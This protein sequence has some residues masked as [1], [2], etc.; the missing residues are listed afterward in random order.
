MSQCMNKRVLFYYRL[1]RISLI[2]S[3]YYFL[4]LVDP[5]RVKGPVG[6]LEGIRIGVHG[7]HELIAGASS[8]PAPRARPHVPCPVPTDIRIDH[9]LHGSKAGSAVAITAAK[10][11]V[12]R[13]LPPFPGINGAGC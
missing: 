4:L 8:R 10:W 6:F 13:W 5:D 9:H 3:Y 12:G 7:I 2:H 1:I 11:V